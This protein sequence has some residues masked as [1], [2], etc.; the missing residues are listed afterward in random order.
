MHYTLLLGLH[1]PACAEKAIS[2][3]TSTR[4][5]PQ[6]ETATSKQINIPRPWQWHASQLGSH[7]LCCCSKEPAS[8]ADLNC[9]VTSCPKPRNGSSDTGSQVSSPKHQQWNMK[10]NAHHWVQS[11]LSWQ[12]PQ[13]ESTWVI[14]ILQEQRKANLFPWDLSNTPLSAWIL[15]HGGKD[16]TALEDESNLRTIANWYQTAQLRVSVSLIHANERQLQL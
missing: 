1:Q 9:T 11:R 12:Q 7:Q 4:F 3:Q 13:L 6:L 15:S 16:G 8:L 2:F 14:S 5:V 10:P